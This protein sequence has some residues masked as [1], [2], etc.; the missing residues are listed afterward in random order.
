MSRQCDTNGHAT[1]TAME[2]G[3]YSEIDH[4]KL[5][6]TSWS[7]IHLGLDRHDPITLDE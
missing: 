7:D 1:V 5:T 4:A 3:V 6:F 2:Y